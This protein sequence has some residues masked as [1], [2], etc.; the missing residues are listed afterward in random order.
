M[1][2][3]VQLLKE[4]TGTMLENVRIT[5]NVFVKD[6]SFRKL[7]HSLWTAVPALSGPTLD[8]QRSLIP[9]MSTSITDDTVS[10]E[11][12]LC[13]PREHASQLPWTGSAQY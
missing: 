5:P 7:G 12:S 6:G 10:L 4:R 11:S 9:K 2:S 3:Q 1:G 8:L 13:L